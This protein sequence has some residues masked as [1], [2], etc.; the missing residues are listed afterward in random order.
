MMKIFISVQLCMLA[1]AQAALAGPI[2][3]A[4]SNGNHSATAD[5]VRSGDDLLV[6]LT[7]TSLFDVLESADVLTAVFFE[8]DGDPALARVSALLSPGSSILVG[9]NGA[10]VTPADRAVGGEWSYLNGIGNLTNHNEGISSTG[11]G[12]FGPGNRFPGANLQG[13]TSPNGV[14]YGIT[15]AGDN[16]LTGNGGLSGEHLIKNSVVF[17]LSGFS[18]EPDA[19][20]TSARFLYGTSLSEPQFEG[21][22]VPE[23]S[24]YLLAAIGAVGLLAARRRNR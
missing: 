9:N 17:M 19:V 1:L 11:V 12:A 5:F 7:N 16:L 15:S 20:I 23:P 14:Q 3:F 18:W 24:A 2:S 4:F 21:T 13:P 10:D 8:V 22:L 6:T